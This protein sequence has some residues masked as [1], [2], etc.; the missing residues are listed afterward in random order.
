LVE[1][2]LVLKLFHKY[3]LHLYHALYSLLGPDV[4]VHTY[5]GRTWEANTGGW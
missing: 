5:S 3:F 1:I 2:E 4:I